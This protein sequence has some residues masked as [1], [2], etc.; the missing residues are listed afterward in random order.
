MKTRRWLEYGPALIAALAI[1]F[2][3][4]VRLRVADVPLERDE[5]EYAYAGQLILQ[6]VPPYVLAYNMKFPGTYYMY[7]LLMAVFG[8]TAWGIH[9][10]LLLVSALSTILLFAFGRRLIGEWG[11]AA[12]AALFA[13]FT[14]D[15]WLMGVFAHATH[16][17]VLFAL[18]GLWLLHRAL[19]SRRLPAFMLSGLCLGLAVM[20]KQPGATFLVLAMA[21]VFWQG[22]RIRMPLVQPIAGLIAGALMPLVVLVIVLWTH[23]ALGRFWFWTFQYAQ[24]YAGQ[25]PVSQGISMLMYAS[26]VISQVSWP[27]WLLSLVGLVLLRFVKWPRETRVWLFGLTLAGIAAASAGFQFRHH[28]FLLVVP[29]AALLAGAGLVSIGRL[30][31]L[32]L[33]RPA[34]RALPVALALVII[35]GYVVAERTYLFSM[36]ATAVSRSL[37]GEHPFVE[38]PAIGAYL[39]EH[40]APNDRIGILGSEPEIPFYAQ[41][42]SAS[43]HLY[44]YPLFEPQPY[45]AQ[46]EAEMIREIESARPGYIVYVSVG[47]SWAVERQLPNNPRMIPWAQSFAQA[48]YDVVGVADIQPSGTAMV[49]DAEAGGYQPRGRSVVFTMKRKATGCA[50]R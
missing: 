33:P 38:A 5:G 26:G 22:R 49:W 50:P 29:S 19:E 4:Y 8:Q 46:M 36:P 7:A 32:A 30:A 35:G 20:M 17:V 25:T 9:V 14:A 44:T 39:K 34:A 40:T 23:G 10:G 2:A 3:A 31:A 1:V 24:A 27:F 11:A 28:Y 37:Y 45:A 47:G 21:L 12:A 42:I 16:F 48:C 18:A 15:R 41:R 6:G 13:I 43:G